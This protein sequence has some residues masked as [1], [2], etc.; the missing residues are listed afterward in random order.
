L[1][2]SV[3]QNTGSGIKYGWT[4]PSTGFEGYTISAV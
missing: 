4:R 1:T 3:A 2:S